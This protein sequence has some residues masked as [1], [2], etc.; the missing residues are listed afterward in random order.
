MGS[1]WK[2][3]VVVLASCGALGA[4]HSG[5]DDGI[6]RAATHPVPHVAADPG[7]YELPAIAQPPDR[8]IDL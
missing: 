2:K 6:A 7:K 4:C 8:V 3:A 1:S 5:V